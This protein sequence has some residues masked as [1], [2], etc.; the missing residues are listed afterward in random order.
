MSENNVCV[1]VCIERE[2]DIFLT[3]AI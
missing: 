3:H 2:R 1:C